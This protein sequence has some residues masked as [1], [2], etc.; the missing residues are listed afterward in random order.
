MS[1]GLHGSFRFCVRAFAY[2]SS[3]HTLFYCTF[4]FILHSCFCERVGY[5]LVRLDGAF[6]GLAYVCL[7]FQRFSARV[8]PHFRMPKIGLLH[9]CL[10]LGIQVVMGQAQRK[11]MA[12]SN[13]AG[14]SFYA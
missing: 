2:Q 12:D 3:S 11:L 14:F 13:A 4:T 1:N 7:T 5:G 9:S 8:D 6:M 10:L